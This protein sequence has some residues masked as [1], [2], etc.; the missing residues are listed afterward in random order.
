MCVLMSVIVSSL[1]AAPASGH[2]VPETVVLLHGL[3]RTSV[4]MAPLACALEREGFRVVNVSYPSL[5]RPLEALATDWLQP[6]VTAESNAPRIHFVT[7]SMGGILVRVWLRDCGAPA[8]LGR[9]VMLAPPNRGSEIPDRFA[10]IAPVRWGLGVNGRR[11]GTS[12]EAL[13][14]TL[15][16]W[17]VGASDLGI[18]AGDR[19]M[20]PFLGATVP[21]PHDGKVSVTST[22]LS[23]EREHLVLPYSHTWLG[24]RAATARHVTAFLREGKF[25]V[26]R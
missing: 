19:S 3:G 2:A 26:A 11:L 6:L 22:H 8:N 9:V 10:S 13:P 17:P 12:D 18:I 23:G 24:W 4:S 21:R 25:Q 16:A 5:T 14:T 1:Y 20:N 15:G 7:H